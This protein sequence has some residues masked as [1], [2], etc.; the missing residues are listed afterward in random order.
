MTLQASLRIERVWAMPFNRPYQIQ[1]ISELLAQEKQPG[2]EWLDV[3]PFGPKIDVLQRLKDIETN[4]LA[5]LTLDPPY[6]PRQAKEE[7]QLDL[8]AVEF[9]K[10]LTLVKDEMARVIRPG[11]K[12]ICLGWNSNGLGKSRGFEM[13]RVLLVPHGGFHNDTIVTVERKVNQSLPL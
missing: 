6:S 11:G 12:V 7:Y 13:L 9:T 1:P 2:G 5:G 8:D 4:S 3:F 10:L